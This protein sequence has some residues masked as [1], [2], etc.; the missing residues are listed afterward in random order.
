MVAKSLS[1]NKIAFGR[2]A[3]LATDSVGMS[4]E[5]AFWLYDDKEKVWRFFF[6]TSLFD[7]IGPR[8]IYLRLNRSLSRKLSARE[9]K[10]FAFYIS[11]PK[12]KF[13]KELYKHVHTTVH[14]SEAIETS[15]GA[16]GHRIKA[17]VYRMAPKMPG[18]KVKLAQRRFRKLS[19]ELGVV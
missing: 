17:H 16:N 5:G 3:L 12:D 2:A 4:A 7:K 14:A 19:S 9:A 15:F 10:N 11:D 6:V 8:E 13:V 1:R 18:E